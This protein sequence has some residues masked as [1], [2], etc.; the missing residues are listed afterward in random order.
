MIDEQ[1]LLNDFRDLDD[2]RQQQIADAIKALVVEFPRKPKLSLIR[3]LV[4]DLLRKGLQ[5]YK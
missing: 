2:T 3:P 5:H 1:E 4:P